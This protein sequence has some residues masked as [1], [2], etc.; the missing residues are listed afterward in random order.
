MLAS[1][2]F[3]LVQSGSID[4]ANNLGVN[5]TLHKLKRLDCAPNNRSEL[6]L[7]S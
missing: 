3:E 6:A 2:L 5:P 7:K 4:I 1:Y